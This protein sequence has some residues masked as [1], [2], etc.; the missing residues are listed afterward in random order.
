MWG[1][2]FPRNKLDKKVYTTYKVINLPLRFR[3]SIDRIHL[4]NDKKVNSQT[5][6]PHK[7]TPTSPRLEYG[8]QIDLIKTAK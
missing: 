8:L 2:F 4:Q 5:E 6:G 7:E 1:S 3:S